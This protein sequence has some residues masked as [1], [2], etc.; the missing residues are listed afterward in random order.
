MNRKYRK[1]SK[2]TTMRHMTEHEWDDLIE[3][4]NENERIAHQFFELQASVL[5]IHN[6]RDFFD[7]LLKGIEERFKVPY[8][9]VSLITSGRVTRL[10][11]TFIA[12]EDFLRHLN[13]IDREAFLQITD[14]SHKPR[15]ANSD[16]EIYRNLLPF[17]QNM[18]FRS[19][20]MVPITFEG[21]PAGSLNFADTSPERYQPGIDTGFLAQLG[22]IVSICLSN[23]AAHEELNTL[24]FKDPLT[25]LLNRRAMENVLKREFGRARRYLIPMSLIFIDLDHFKKVN[26]TYGHD[27]G[28]DLLK[29]VAT[30][31]SEM[32]RESDII[33]RFAGDEFVIILP[34]TSVVEAEKF[35]KRVKEYFNDNSLNFKGDRILAQFTCGI[36]SVGDDGVN[37]PV[38][39]IKK[40]DERLYVAKETRPEGRYH[41]KKSGA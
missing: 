33:A 6:F 25:G 28:D 27:Y 30:S 1:A 2:E 11:K 23:V 7:R 22:M 21:K 5:S 3:R 38:A 40:A 39:L 20:A 10:V 29:F 31:L 4:L 19:F 16:L 12:S 41:R 35:I 14:G 26:D 32:A 15:L 36:S 24:A 34:G 37:D 9:W 8:V 17:G 18:P 13:F